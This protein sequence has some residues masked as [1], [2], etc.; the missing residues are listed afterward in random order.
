MS[1]AQIT[2]QSV[3]HLRYHWLYH[4]HFSVYQVKK[5]KFA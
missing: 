2:A 1:D 4:S 5:L 3:C